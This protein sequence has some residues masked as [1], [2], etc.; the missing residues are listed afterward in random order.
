MP[1]QVNIF[2]LLFGVIQGVLF[3]LFLVKRK[4]YQGGYIFLLFYFAVLLLQIG[5]KV[6]NKLWLMQHWWVLYE[7][8]YYLPMLYGPIVF[9]FVRQSLLKHKFRA[10]DILHFLPFL[11]LVMFLIAFSL[12]SFTSPVIGF[13][14][15]SFS[16]LTMQLASLVLYHYFALQC[17]SRYRAS[18]QNYFSDTQRLQ[19]IWI[20]QFILASFA[21]CSVIAVAIY[22]IYVHFPASQPYRY[23]FVI[24]TCYIYWVS[25]TALTKPSVFS[26]IK[27]Y[28]RDTAILPV[29][30]K[31]VVHRPSPKYSNS[32]MSGEEKSGIIA[33]L[34][35]VMKEEKPFLNA[36][37]TINDLAGMVKCNRHHLSQVLNESLQQSFYEYINQFRVAEA[38]QMLTDPLKAEY[39]I[40]SIA[41]DAGFNSLS[42]FNDVFRKLT[43][44]T[45]SRYKKNA[46]QLPRQQHG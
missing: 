16:L 11:L 4:F 13:F 41:Y 9:L 8:S 45:P 14:Y 6:M 23:L 38:R 29:V 31:L 15:R 24:L 32:G 12:F 39:K 5:L 26:V 42:T 3:W 40:A 43:G 37:L 44:S 46:R 1:A 2:L 35:R 20:R 17:W 27:G 36:E 7:I 18:L 19:M 25:Y 21:V 10:V 22:L 28:A 34:L 33:S 30:P